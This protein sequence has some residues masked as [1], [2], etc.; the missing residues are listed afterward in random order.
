MVK[1]DPPR[2]PES[3]RNV[4]AYQQAI[5]NYHTYRSAKRV[6]RQIK[7]DER[8]WILST[9]GY[10]NAE[11]AL[12]RDR[13]N[14]LKELKLKMKHLRFIQFYPRSPYRRSLYKRLISGREPV[15]D[16]YVTK[17]ER[18][19]RGLGK[20]TKAQEARQRERAAKRKRYTVG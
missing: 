17:H 18:R 2:A 5:R 3:Y 7:R 12:D 16:V 20:R 8:L 19:I 14:D 6:W 1:V 4:D 15:R 9:F 13:N 11:A 10:K